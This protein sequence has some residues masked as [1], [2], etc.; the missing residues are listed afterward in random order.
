MGLEE[1]ADRFRLQHPLVPE[2][3]YGRLAK[4]RPVPEAVPEVVAPSA[5]TAPTAPTTVTRGGDASAN[6][7][8]ILQVPKLSLRR[9]SQSGEGWTTVQRQNKEN[10]KESPGLSTEK[11]VP[12]PVS[13]D[14]NSGVYSR[15]A[16]CIACHIQTTRCTRPTGG[17]S[18]R[19]TSYQGKRSRFEIK[20][21]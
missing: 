8:V 15:S 6:P 9:N 17:A 13:K 21:S 12:E 7:G 16:Q 2:P 11:A 18:K 4:S 3:I 1:Y 5:P 20:L 14:M 10:Y 19:S